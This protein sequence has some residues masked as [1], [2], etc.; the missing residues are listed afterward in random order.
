M[1]NKSKIQKLGTEQRNR[2]ARNLDTKSATKI[3]RI[4]N[5]EDAKVATAVKRALPQIAKAIDVIAKQIGRGGRLIY[6]GCGT[7]GRI[8]ALDASEIPPTFSTD[9]STV[10]YLMAGGAKALGTAAEYNEDSEADGRR[11]M[12]AR[13]PGKNDV[14]VGVAASGRT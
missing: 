3:A 10:Q 8:A 2:A 7:S 5:Q 1:A 13:K 4:I 14:V 6:V 9:P 12:A 11:D